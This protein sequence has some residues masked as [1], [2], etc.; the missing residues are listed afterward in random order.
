MKHKTLKLKCICNGYHAIE[1]VFTDDKDWPCFIN[2]LGCHPT[3]WEKI[4]AFFKTDWFMDDMIIDKEQIKSL[5]MFLK[6]N[7]SDVTR[8]DISQ[9]CVEYKVPP[10]SDV[11]KLFGEIGI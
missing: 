7:M 10:Q 11:D 8:D 3:L 2:M 4:K 6:M 1:F 5:Y 9:S